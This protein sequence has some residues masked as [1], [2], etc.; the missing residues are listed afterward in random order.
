MLNFNARLISV[1][2]PTMDMPESQRYALL[3]KRLKQI[4]QNEMRF[5]KDVKH[6]LK[7]ASTRTV[8][9]RYWDYEGQTPKPVTM[10]NGKYQYNT[11]LFWIDVLTLQLKPELVTPSALERIQLKIEDDTKEIQ[12]ETKRSIGY[13]PTLDPEHANVWLLFV[14]NQGYKA[15]LSDGITYDTISEFVNSLDDDTK[16]CPYKSFKAWQLIEPTLIIH[17]GYRT[18]DLTQTLVP[19]YFGVYSGEGR[20]KHIVILEEEASE[21]YVGAVVE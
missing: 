2:A 8:L 5:R 18:N 16:S 12:L 13:W 15:V 7:L 11:A 14:A 17:R 20:S 10:P 21:F 4:G 6:M 3:L 9:R 1:M 19:C